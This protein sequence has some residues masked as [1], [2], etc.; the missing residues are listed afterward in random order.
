MPVS[1]SVSQFVTTGRQDP[2]LQ[3]PE[4]LGVPL[5]QN[6]G[7]IIVRVWMTEYPGTWS[8]KTQPAGKSD[9]FLSELREE[10]G[11][12]PVSRSHNLP[13]A[14]SSFLAGDPLFRS[15]PA[16]PDLFTFA[17]RTDRSQSAIRL[18]DPAS[19][20]RHIGPFSTNSGFHTIGMHMPTSSLAGSLNSSPIQT[21]QVFD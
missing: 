7:I 5:H 11:P 15:S 3:E 21:G 12:F 10:L 13:P 14:P 16:C 17:R 8:L 9:Q 1:V 20:F 4:S 18:A 19:G 6:R 2:P